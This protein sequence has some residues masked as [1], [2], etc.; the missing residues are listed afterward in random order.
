[1]IKLQDFARQ[2]GVTDRQVQRLLRK[3]AADLDGKYER[4]GPNGTWLS[5]EACEIL[6]GKMRQAPVTVVTPDDRATELQAQLEAVKAELYTVQR[7]YTAYVSH[8]T[9]LLTQASQQLALAER[10]GE[11]KARADALEAQNASLSAEIT[12]RDQLLSAEREYAAALEAWMR[13]P[14]LKRI[15]TPRPTR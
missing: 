6:R 9:P 5:D 3:Y 2:Q 1:M 12:V 11:H 15:R 13:L 4:T 14:W 7:E 8:A 10:A